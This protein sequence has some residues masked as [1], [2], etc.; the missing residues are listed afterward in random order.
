MAERI[1]ESIKLL[2]EK[3]YVNVFIKGQLISKCP[4]SVFKSLKKRKRNFFQDF[5][6][7]KNFVG[8]L[9]DLKT[10]KGHFKIN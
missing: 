7:G 4:F 6:P 3:S 10:L 1:S 8:F 2:Q 5:C 9:E